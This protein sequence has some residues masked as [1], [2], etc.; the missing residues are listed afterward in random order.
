[1]H[2]IAAAGSHVGKVRSNNQDSAYAG[3]HLFM[4]ADGMGGHAGGDVASAIT[5]RHVRDVDRLFDDI[6]QAAEALQTSLVGAN[7]ALAETVYQHAELAG[8][9]TTVSALLRVD[10]QFSLAHI[11]DSRIYLLRNG[12]LRQLTS[13]H[14]FV[15]RLVDSGRITPEEAL[16]HPRRSVLMRVLGDVESPPEL[17]REL[18]DIKPGDRWMLCSDGLSSYV[19]DD[20]SKEILGESPTPASAV[21]RLINESLANG[22][23]DNVTVVVVD[24]SDNEGVGAPASP[25]TV[26]SAAE[27][28]AF[29][30]PANRRVFR[31]PTVALRH[32]IKAVTT[33]EAHFEPASEEYLEQ[34][35]AEDQRRANRRRMRWL[36]VLAFALLISGTLLF[37]GYQWTQTRYF[38]GSQ[39]GNVAIFQG[40]QQDVG[41]ITLSHLHTD[42]GIP[43]DS[44]PPFYQLRLEDTISAST[45]A[46][47]QAVVDRIND[48]RD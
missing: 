42:T 7:A 19:D 15:Q 34:L 5:V 39:D 6:G 14:T 28:L 35:I 36:F 26:G 38:V 11:G 10:D 30:T 29:D 18:V 31:I 8:M 24:A 44:L 41:P 33:E 43:V 2:M 23:P 3:R 17:D 32:P 25:I 9:G 4:V 13:D 37:F 46:E 48:V 40:V 22:A 47:A 16:V 21:E 1:M 20:R 45:L 27:P 12:D